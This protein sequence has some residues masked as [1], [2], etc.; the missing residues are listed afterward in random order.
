[1]PN[2]PDTEDEADLFMCEECHSVYDSA[3]DYHACRDS[4]ERTPSRKG[5]R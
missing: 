5:D 2:H 3:S 1:M 4:H